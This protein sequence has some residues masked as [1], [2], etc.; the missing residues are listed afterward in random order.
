MIP[1]IPTT[2]PTDGTEF[3]S[4]EKNI[5]HPE[6]ADSK[7]VHIHGYIYKNDEGWS[8]VECIFLTVPLT[9]FIK[10]YSERGGDYIDELYEGAKQCQ[11]DPYNDAQTVDIINRFY[12]GKP[13][14][15]KLEFSELTTETPLGNYIH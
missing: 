5:Y 4:I 15:A 11:N 1:F 13:A 14:T 7:C 6:S 12:N 9:E 2:K 3:F 8:L 10:N